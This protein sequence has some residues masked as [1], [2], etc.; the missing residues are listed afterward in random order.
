MD[1]RESG[2]DRSLH[3]AGEGEPLR[4][5]L[6]DPA[7]A[8]LGTAVPLPL[9]DHFAKLNR[10]RL[11][12]EAFK[13]AHLRG[14]QGQKRKRRKRKACCAPSAAGRPCADTLRSEAR[15]LLLQP[16]QQVHKVV[17][18]R[19]GETRSKFI[20]RCME[21]EAGAFPD[22]KQRAAVCNAKADG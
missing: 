1:A 11:L 14:V 18:R 21:A 4:G 10:K 20:S 9:G 12:G 7:G 2:G 5:G 19:G 17:N 16:R 8:H 13:A 15:G 6:L 22:A 3:S